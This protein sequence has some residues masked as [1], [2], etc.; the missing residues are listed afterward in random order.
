M[1]YGCA[2][3]GHFCC[4][5]SNHGRWVDM[6][7][8]KQK[9]VGDPITVP[10]IFS[11]YAFLASLW[12]HQILSF[13]QISMLT[14]FLFWGLHLRSNDVIDVSCRCNRSRGGCASWFR[15]AWRPQTKHWFSI[16]ETESERGALGVRHTPPHCPPTKT[17]LLNQF[18]IQF[19]SMMFSTIHL[20]LNHKGRLDPSVSCTC[21]SY[22]W[23]FSFYWN[24][25][26]VARPEI[27]ITFRTETSIEYRLRSVCFG[28]LLIMMALKG[29]YG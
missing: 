22:N 6:T 29:P 26:N 15:T 7:K 17:S 16:F 27:F 11:Q 4:F 21:S 9:F 20:Y 25:K 12:L 10:I 19:H 24:T 2:V 13:L 5:V 28:M 3:H 23:L 18:H 8:L 14:V 1:W